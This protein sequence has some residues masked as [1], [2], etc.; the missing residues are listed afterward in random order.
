MVHIGIY[1]PHKQKL[2]GYSIFKE[3]EMVPKTEGLRVVWCSG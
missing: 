1:N 2:F 3:D